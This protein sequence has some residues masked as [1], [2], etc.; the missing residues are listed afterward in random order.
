MLF[1]E[2]TLAL[3]PELKEEVLKVVEGLAEQGMTMM[4]VTHEMNFARHV[5]N[6]LV[7][8]RAVAFTM[9]V[10]PTHSS[11]IQIRR[12]FGNSSQAELSDPRESMDNGEGPKPSLLSKKSDLVIATFG[13]TPERAKTVAFSDPHSFIRSVISGKRIPRFPA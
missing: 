9:L 3:D 11:I 10:M 6:K 12:N 4:M 1:D 8:C 2:V 13:Y 5:P 7:L